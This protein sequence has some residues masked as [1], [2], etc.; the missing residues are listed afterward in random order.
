[1]TW[2]CLGLLCEGAI[3]EMPSESTVV[4]A[5]A[6]NKLARTTVKTNFPFSP[7]QTDFGTHD[8]LCPMHGFLYFHL[9]NQKCVNCPFFC[10]ATLDGRR[11]E[12]QTVTLLGRQT[13][14]L[15]KSDLAA[16]KKNRERKKGKEDMDRRKDVLFCCASRLFDVT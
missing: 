13:D 12:T 7:P 16:G 1:M 15:C 6:E 4:I 11:S 2:L 10:M 14:R 3:K 5:D 9:C 8:S